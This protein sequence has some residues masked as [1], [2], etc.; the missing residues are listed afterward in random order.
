MN[1]EYTPKQ[2]EA[3]NTLNENLQIIACAGSGKTDVLSM[4]VV[5]ILETIKDITPGNIVAFTFTEKAAGELKTRIY[6]RVKENIGEIT[7]MAE[8][9]VGTIHSFC[10][11]ILQDYMNDYQKFSVLDEVK[12]KL[13][14]DKNFS[15]IGMKNLN[16]ERYKDTDI[17]MI[18]IGILKESE[19]ENKKLPD[20]LKQTLIEYNN[21]F[22]K[23]N[24][25]DFSMIMEKA[26]IHLENDLELRKKIS[27]Q[28]KYLLVDEYQDVNP[29]QEKLIS[30]IHQLGANLCVVGDDDQTIYQWRGSEIKN[31]LEFDKRY[32]GNLESVILADNFRS[33]QGIIDLANITIKNNINR[34]EKKM[35]HKSK[36][37]YEEGDILY[38]EFQEPKDECQFIADRIKD[39]QKVGLKLSDVAILM[40]IK[41]LGSVLIE[42]LKKNEIKFI[43]EGV[44][45]L[46]S[47]TEALA[48]KYIFDYLNG[49]MDKEALK[50]TWL[51][52][53]HKLDVKK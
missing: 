50:R 40:R 1:V 24:Y 39:L 49:E 16:M 22:E 26:I 35:I 38:K 8:M 45:E 27:S 41:R 19:M 30:I 33:T 20:K 14:I 52:I 48:S 17:F 3:I 46:F 5:R 25:F 53:D 47:T 9:Y 23:Y 34:K 18:L 10:L 28:I 13:F 44:N 7:G 42:V 37:I 21:C 2:L 32:K 11:K 15:D 31:I 4:R 29:I 43:V 6:K 36:Y 12:T 51:S